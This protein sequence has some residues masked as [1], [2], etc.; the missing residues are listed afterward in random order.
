MDKG[1]QIIND[2]KCYKVIGFEKYHVSESGRVY[3]TETGRPRTWRTKG[4]AYINENKVHFDI[5]NDVIKRGFVCLTDTE[6]K[7]HNID[8]SEVVAMAFGVIEGKLNKRKQSIVHIDGDKRN[9]HY[10]NLQV[11]DKKHSN[12][13]LTKEDVKHIRKQIKMGVPLRKIAWFFSV[14]EMQINRIKT[15]ENWG[16]GKRKLKAPEAPFEIEDGR[17]RKYIATFNNKKTVTKVKKP[18][19]VKRNAEKPTDNTIVGIVNGY[20]LW[21]KHANITR[22]KQ[23]VDKLNDYF[24]KE[25][26][27]PSKQSGGIFKDLTEV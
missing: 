20:K 6:G 10:T 11:G 27:E 21:I 26:P 22:A 24:F 15:G 13:K 5:R 8:V 1:L 3:R 2:E 12:S 25:M 4:R 16:T 14:S 19:A 7:L 18:F 17:M 9:L 23:L